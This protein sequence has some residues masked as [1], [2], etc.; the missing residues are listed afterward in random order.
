M[1]K[2][3]LAIM[4]EHSEQILSGVV[5]GFDVFVLLRA[6]REN[7]FAVHIASSEARLEFLKNMLS[8]VAPDVH[9]LSFPAWDTIPYDRVSPNP[10]I[11]SERL[12]ALSCLA[13][14]S[15]VEAT[16][17]LTCASAVLQKVPPL[18]FFKGKT[19]SFEIGDTL[20]ITQVQKFLNQNG[21]VRTEQVVQSGEYALRGG[22]IDVFASGAEEGYRLDLFGDVLESIRLFDPATQKTTATVQK[23][24]LKP[25]SEYVLD[26]QTISSFRTRYR[27]LASG[28]TAGDMLYESISAGRKISGLEHWLPLFF[29][30][31][32]T[33]FD[34]LPTNS[35][36]YLDENLSEAFLSRQTQI[37]EYYQSRLD[38]LKSKDKFENVYYPVPP[39]SFFLDKT[40][41][42]KKLSLFDRFVFSS[43]I[44][45][46]TQDLGS[47]VGE[48][49]AAD[50]M[51]GNVFEKLAN[52]IKQHQNL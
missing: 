7:G 12:D 43:F 30:Q 6:A 47:R 14:E 4:T 48:T 36:V 24:I 40:L 26:E 2:S 27:S 52:F 46:Q 8:V 15:F 39:D 13:N 33:F 5:A 32:D 44:S 9:V 20:D 50:R 41:L 3:I 19:L 21:Y 16:I 45:P 51:A 10:M 25:M 1:K 18:D 37:F 38:A 49:F 42:Q 29:E 31:M 11:E 34:Y 23:F 28:Q 22:I 17:V 35:V